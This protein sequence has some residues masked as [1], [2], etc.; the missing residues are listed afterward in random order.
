MSLLHPCCMYKLHVHVA[1]PCWMSVLHVHV[2]YRCCMSV[3]HVLTACP[4]CMSMQH[5]LTACRTSCPFSMSLMHVPDECLYQMSKQNVHAECPCCISILNV[6]AACICCLY[7]TCMSLLHCMLHF[8]AAYP[9]FM[10]MIHVMLHVNAS[11]PY[12][13][14]MLHVLAACPSC[15]S[16]LYVHAAIHAHAALWCFISG[17]WKRKIGC[18]IIRK[19]RSEVK[20]KKDEFFI[21][22]SI[23]VF[24]TKR[25]LEAKSSETKRKNWFVCVT[26]IETGSAP[27][28]ITS[29]EKEF[30]M[31][32]VHVV[33]Q[34]ITTKTCSWEHL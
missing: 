10:S 1:S 14:S 4:Y 19:I 21:H 13:M 31:K 33:A 24:G 16:M 15:M 17:N 3:L 28:R 34:K 7:S 5:V 2:S 18:E 22:V 27:L 25:K 20:R 30:K 32:P 9:C 26:K 23:F 8:H 11:C 6:H 29:N 12:C